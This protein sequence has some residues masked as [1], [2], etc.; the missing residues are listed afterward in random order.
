MIG[1]SMRD[2]LIQVQSSVI[3]LVYYTGEIGRW[4]SPVDPSIVFSVLQGGRCWEEDKSHQP[5]LWRGRW[6]GKSKRP[7]QR[8]LGGPMGPIFTRVLHWR[9]RVDNGCDQIGIL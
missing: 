3:S 9:R 4:G 5:P 8:V 2:S 6:R 1:K 7:K